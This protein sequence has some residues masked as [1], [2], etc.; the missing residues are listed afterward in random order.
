MTSL[1][2]NDSSYRSGAARPVVRKMQRKTVAALVALALGLI[3]FF[4]VIIPARSASASPMVA[5]PIAQVK[6]INYMP[7]N[8]S[9]QNMWT[10]WN[11]TQLASDYNQIASLG[12]NTVRV[13]I[14]MPTFNYPVPFASMTSRLSSVV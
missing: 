7:V 4:A 5:L 14:P 1:P 12:D 13:T 6:D 2:A 10:N 9:W 3:A 11:A 8:A